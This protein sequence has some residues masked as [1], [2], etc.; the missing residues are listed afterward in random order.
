MK[1]NFNRFKNAKKLAEQLESFVHTME[2]KKTAKRNEERKNMRTNVY[3]GAGNPGN[4]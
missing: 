4:A 2:L 3:M 1:Q